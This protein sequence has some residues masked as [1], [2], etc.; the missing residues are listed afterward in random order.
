MELKLIMADV[1]L[2][3]KISAN[4]RREGVIF[5]CVVYKM[6]SIGY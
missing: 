4:L 1:H 6:D 3:A 5:I 2:L